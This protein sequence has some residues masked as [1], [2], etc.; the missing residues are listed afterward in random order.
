MMRSG[1]AQP[2]KLF[3]PAYSIGVVM[4]SPKKG[5]LT[6]RMLEELVPTEPRDLDFGN[7]E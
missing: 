4:D 3:Q 7:A 1:M 2:P 6:R 5:F